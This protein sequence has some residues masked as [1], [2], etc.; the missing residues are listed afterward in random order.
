MR[1][2][3]QK[4][5][6]KTKATISF[7]I[8]LYRYYKIVNFILTDNDIPAFIY[9]W[10]NIMLSYDRN[11]VIIIDIDFFCYHSPIALD[12]LSFSIDYIISFSMH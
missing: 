11:F 8:K 2:Y 1:V 10:N 3:N 9:P 4:Y 6:K 5:N 12:Y 7:V